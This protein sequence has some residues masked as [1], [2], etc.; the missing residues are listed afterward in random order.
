VA[1]RAIDALSADPSLAE[2]AAERLVRRSHHSWAARTLEA[3][4]SLAGA[5]AAWERAGYAVRASEI[6]DR[7]GNPVRAARVLEMALRRAPRDGAPRW[8]WV[9]CS[10]ASRR[11]K[12]R[13]ARSSASRRPR[14]SGA[15]PFPSS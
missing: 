8:R 5:A 10:S 9:R 7:L 15:T 6:L 13:R 12:R 3:V 2:A 11:T 4:G 14:R 1:E